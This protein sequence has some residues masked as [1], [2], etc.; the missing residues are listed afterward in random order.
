[1][2]KEIER[3]YIETKRTG[4]R[5]TAEDFYKVPEKGNAPI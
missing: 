2:A 1:M 5:L 4:G 3:L